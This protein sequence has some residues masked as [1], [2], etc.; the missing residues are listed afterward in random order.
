MSHEYYM[1][2]EV[3]GGHKSQ[4]EAILDEVV[5]K[6]WNGDYGQVTG[7]DD[8]DHGV[9]IEG[10][11][12]LTGGT[13]PREFQSTLQARLRDLFGEKIS[14]TVLGTDREGVDYGE[15]FTYGPP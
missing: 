5:P 3:R 15:R 6:W 12:R 11:D 4:A 7:M 13:D 2:I 10:K 8:A 14:A 1:R 9:W